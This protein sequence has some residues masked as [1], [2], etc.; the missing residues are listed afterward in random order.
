[1]KYIDKVLAYLGEPY[2]IA[3][4]D[5]ETCIVREFPNFEFEVSGVRS[6]KHPC[7][8]YVWMMKPHV[9]LMGIYQ[10]IVGKE[11]LK[12]L[13]GY[14]AAKYQNLPEKVHVE[15]EDKIE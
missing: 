15:R 2:I 1:M 8:L 10:G 11:A 3:T 9:E 5:L 14:Y 4:R 13:L 12:D 6:E 7:T